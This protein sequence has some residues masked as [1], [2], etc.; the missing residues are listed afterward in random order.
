MFLRQ[1]LQHFLIAD[2]PAD[3]MPASPVESRFV[4]VDS[5][6]FYLLPFGL[7]NVKNGAVF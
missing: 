2:A 5:G 6:H 7:I 1:G 3:L 4:A